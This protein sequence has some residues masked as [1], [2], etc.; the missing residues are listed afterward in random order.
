MN[1]ARNCFVVLVLGAGLAAINFFVAAE[2]MRG[3]TT[4]AG[5]RLSQFPFMA[6][7]AGVQPLARVDCAHLFA[8]CLTVNLCSIWRDQRWPD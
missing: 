3:L 1:K 8:L 5:R 4:F 2:G 7:A 6:W